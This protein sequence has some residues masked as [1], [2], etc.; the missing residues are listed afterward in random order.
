MFKEH[1]GNIIVS[2]TIEYIYF[3]VTFLFYFI[4]VDKYNSHL[5]QEYIRYNIAQEV[6]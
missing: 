6:Q 4:P 1:S 5:D 3:L 2:I